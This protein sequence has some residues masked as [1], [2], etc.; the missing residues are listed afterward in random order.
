MVSTPRKQALTRWEAQAGG[1]ARQ[2]WGLIP[3]DFP[4]SCPV[5]LEP[6]GPSMKSLSVQLQGGQK[7]QGSQRLLTLED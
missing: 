5:R 3:Q 2:R 6:G 4:S 7:A 1:A